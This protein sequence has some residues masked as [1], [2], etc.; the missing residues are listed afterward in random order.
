M[1]DFD[2]IVTNPVLRRTFL[3]RVGMLGAGAMVLGS[4]TTGCGSDDGD[5]AGDNSSQYFDPT[6]F[7][8][9][10][11]RSANEVVLNYALTLEHLEAD[12]Y[13]QALNA[14]SGRELT[15]PLDT[16]VSSYALASADGGLGTR[17][18]A[19]YAYLVQYAYVEAQ[20]A[21]FLQTAVANSGG[22]P[23]AA[24]A[25]GY[26]FGFTKGQDL[27]SLLTTI[28]TFEETGVRAYLGAVPYLTDF[29]LIQVAATIYSTEARHSA[30]I[31]Y[32]LGLDAGP[33]PVAGDQQVTAS[34]PS[35]N[36]FEYFKTPTQVL[37]AVLT[38]FR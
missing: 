26:N 19:G 10:Q 20:H 36:T 12:L 7:P 23:V 34:Y 33:A 1:L 30:A 14:A 17:T 6:N 32:V 5:S 4:V 31:N 27:R 18:D 15:A 22:T 38:Y 8:G 3:S 2:Q 35:A 13:R 11:G 16:N 25:N 24:N 29:A 9:V 21:N 37:N 28:R